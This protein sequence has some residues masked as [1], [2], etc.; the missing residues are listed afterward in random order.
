VGSPEQA[1]IARLAQ[2][3][4]NALT[5][6]SVEVML[7]VHG[8]PNLRRVAHTYGASALLEGYELVVL[9][10]RHVELRPQVALKAHLTRAQPTIRCWLLSPEVELID[11]D[12]SAFRLVP[13]SS[14]RW[15][16][17]PPSI[18]VHCPHAARW[19]VEP[20]GSHRNKDDQ[21]LLA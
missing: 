21:F 9:S 2:Q 1:V 18:V 13:A 19:A 6:W 15:E 11:A 7:M 8:E 4:S 16:F 14:F 20:A 12:T 17:A 5:N 3:P 10:E